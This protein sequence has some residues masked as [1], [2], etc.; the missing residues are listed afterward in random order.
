MDSPVPNVPK[1][2]NDNTMIIAIVVV[3][4]ILCTISI[5]VASKSGS[6]KKEEVK[7]EVKE[8][9][10]EE[11]EEVKEEVKKEETIK[12][13]SMDNEEE[14]FASAPPPP[15]PINK[16]QAKVDVNT[17][18]PPPPPPPPP[19]KIVQRK[20]INTRTPPPPPPPIRVIQPPPPPPPPPPVLVRPTPPKPPEPP[21]PPKSRILKIQNTTEKEIKKAIHELSVIKNRIKSMEGYR[22]YYTSERNTG[23]TLIGTV[24]EQ[25]IDITIAILKQPLVSEAVSKQV[26]NN[27][28]AKDIAR[29]IEMLGQEVVNEINKTPILFCGE[30]RRKTKNCT[31]YRVNNLNPALKKA[32]ATLYNKVLAV[33]EKAEE[34]EKMYRITKNVSIDNYKYK[35]LSNGRPIDQKRIDSF[36]TKDKLEPIA[37]AHYKYLGHTLKRELGVDGREINTRNYTDEEKRYI[38]YLDRRKVEVGPVFATPKPVTGGPK[39]GIVYGGPKPP[40]LVAGG[41]KRGIV[42]GGPKPPQ[43]V[44]G[45]P[46]RVMSGSILSGGGRTGKFKKIRS[47]TGPAKG[48]LAI[49]IENKGEKSNFVF[50][51]KFFGRVGD[52]YRIDGFDP[53]DMKN[54]RITASQNV[55]V[56]VR[57]GRK[58][59]SYYGPVSRV[60]NNSKYSVRSITFTI[61]EGKPGS[62]DGIR[63]PSGA[64]K[65]KNTL[66]RR[67]GSAP[68]KLD[69]AY[70][71]ENYGEKSN[72][73]HIRKFKGKLNDVYKVEGFDPND[74]K[75]VRITASE[76]VHVHIKRGRKSVIIKGPVTRA[77][78]QSTKPISGIFVTI[79]R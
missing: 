72:F 7:E 51:Q 1:P 39:R 25:L 52:T 10:V 38:N 44:A 68:P 42:Y 63:I 74:M 43:L 64:V 40:Q 56:S 62:V 41:P 6:S 71:I 50:A 70:A 30:D 17:R 33:V 15:P 31:Q 13:M 47:G 29:Y 5:V 19:V 57:R 34:R 18:V 59:K 36:P 32:T 37:M 54:I 8:E 45:G 26:L 35:M 4:I 53:K 58:G 49:A 65:G 23:F 22:E 60:Q 11:K 27:E 77:P 21:K 76:N 61:V 55:S 28:D 12:S 2:G 73:V 46:K 16:V 24:M 3:V 67:Y 14:V 69:I 79:N 48:N 75:N 20:V 66:M 78:N 9:E